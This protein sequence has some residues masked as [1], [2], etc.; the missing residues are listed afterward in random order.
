MRLAF[1]WVAMLGLGVASLLAY[2]AVAGAPATSLSISKEDAVLPGSWVTS[3]TSDSECYVNPWQ[4]TASLTE[5]RFEHAAVVVSDTIYVLGGYLWRGHATATSTIERA[6]VQPDGTLGN[7]TLDDAQDLT[8]NLG[9]AQHAAVA[10]SNH[11]YVFGG[12]D[13]G[14]QIT[15]SVE[16]AAV[17]PDGTLTTWQMATPMLESRVFAGA[18]RAGEWIY[19]VGGYRA[20]KYLN[21][22]ERAQIAPDGSLLEWQAATPLSTPRTRA[23]VVATEGYL[24]V[25][26]GGA[27]QVDV[28]TRVE[29][30]AILPDGSLGAWEALSPLRVPRSGASV[31]VVDNSLY[32]LGGSERYGW[33]G[34]SRS[35]ERATIDPDGTVRPW[36]LVDEMRDW[37][38][39]GAAVTLNGRIYA[40][41]GAGPDESTVEWVDTSELAPLPDYRLT[42]NDGAL[43]TNQ[44]AVTLKISARPGTVEMQVSNDGGF[45]GAVWEPCTTTKAWTITQHG[46]YVL[47]RTVY[48]RFRDAQGNVSSTFQ[49]DIILDVTPPTGSVEV[50]PLSAASVAPTESPLVGIQAQAN[51]NL[52]YLPAV[53]RLSGGPPPNV[54]LRLRAE[55]DVSGVGHM[56]ISNTPNFVGS[57]WE[58]FTT[59]KPW[60]LPSGATVYVRY[61]DNAGNISEVVTATAT[62]IR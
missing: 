30:A 19:V 34:S 10:T 35:V 15:N 51:N 61:R 13:A 25:M 37:R 1:F 36:V 29:R 39:R 60:Y 28:G 33:V 44:I 57:D 6:T 53:H 54:N 46:S 7:W 38:I 2:S 26:G 20:P 59:T 62:A 3:G 23:S 55:D 48:I 52:L 11:I 17:Q 12:R 43:F 27:E 49:D 32:V 22:I 8:L 21:S 31:V 41:A 58:P 45:A 16:Y 56:M 14:H 24:Y 4:H 5:A 42:I 47:P 40:I 9:R 50:V 18:A